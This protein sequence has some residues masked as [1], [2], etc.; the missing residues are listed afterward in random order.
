M[1][2]GQCTMYIVQYTGVHYTVYNVYSLYS[3][4]YTVQCT[5]YI[6]YTVYNIYIYSIVYMNSIKAIYI[7][8]ELCTVC[9]VQ[10]TVCTVYKNSVQQLNSF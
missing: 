10:C 9:I 2:N 6:H 8:N 5:L 7:L 4:L 1:Y 3:I